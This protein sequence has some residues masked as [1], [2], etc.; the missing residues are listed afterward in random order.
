MPAFTVST[1]APNEIRSVY[2]LIREAVPGLSLPAWLRFARPLTTARKAGHAGI[3]AARRVGRTYPCGL[4]C[5]RVDHDLERGRVLIAEHFVAIDLLDPRAVLAA[6]VTELEALGKR[7]GCTAVRSVVHD[8]TDQVAGWLF[9]AG[10]APEAS[11]LLK[12]LMIEAR[13]PHAPATPRIC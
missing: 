11:L 5:Y 4:F 3:M 1:L 8:G 7:L 10:H 6:L 13:G 12:P 2:P 9:A